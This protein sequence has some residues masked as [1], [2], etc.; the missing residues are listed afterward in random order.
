M[1]ACL[2]QHEGRVVSREYI[3]AHAWQGRITTDNSLSVTVHNLRKC[4]MRV[5]PRS[6]CLVTLPKVGFVF[7]IMGS[8]FVVISSLD[9]IAKKQGGGD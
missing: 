7:S 3:F 4:F 5:D 1:L 6:H 2:L 8:G 9:E